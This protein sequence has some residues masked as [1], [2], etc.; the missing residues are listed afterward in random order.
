MLKLA[1]NRIIP[2]VTGNEVDYA[3]PV[4]GRH[5]D[6]W[7]H[8]LFVLLVYRDSGLHAS[9]HTV[10]HTQRKAFLTGDAPPYI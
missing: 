10:F 5:T 8:F 9:L 7:A 4:H 3:I 1:P 6:R 2:T